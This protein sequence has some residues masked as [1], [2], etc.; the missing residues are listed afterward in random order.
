MES[1]SRVEQNLAQNCSS[2]PM[3]GKASDHRSNQKPC[4]DKTFA[5]KDRLL[6]AQVELLQ[7]QLNL[8][9]QLASNRA[10]V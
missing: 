4:R 9:T 8:P 10:I 2:K 3:N 1:P 6:S 7:Q 5:V